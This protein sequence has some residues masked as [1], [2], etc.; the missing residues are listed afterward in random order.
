M[1]QL[2]DPTLPIEL[3]E[4][5]QNIITEISDE[6]DNTSDLVLSSPCLCIN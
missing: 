2:T 5:D 3:R 6:R 4:V 1:D